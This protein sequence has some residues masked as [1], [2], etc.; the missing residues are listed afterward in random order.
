MIPRLRF[1]VMF[2]PVPDAHD[3][4]A[5]SPGDEQLQQTRRVNQHSQN[6]TFPKQCQ[7]LRQITVQHAC[8]IEDL[9]FGVIVVV[10]IFTVTLAECS[11]VPPHLH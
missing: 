11:L 2:P 7:H 10:E 6:G 4:L 9:L 8:G 1:R 5:P 3:S